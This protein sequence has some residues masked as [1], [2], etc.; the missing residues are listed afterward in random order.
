LDELPA[1]FCGAFLVAAVEP[2]AL[3]V[4]ALLE[5]ADGWP[6]VPLP[7]EVPDFAAGVLGLAAVLLLV[8]ASAFVVVAEGLLAADL[9]AVVTGF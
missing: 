3:P 6:A 7:A 2:D 4:L 5:L 9:L 8:V 1:F